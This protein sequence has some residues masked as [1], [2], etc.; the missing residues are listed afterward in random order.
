MS[1]DLHCLL[2]KLVV[3]LQ[4]TNGFSTLAIVLWLLSSLHMN[5]A[6]WILLSSPKLLHLLELV[7][8]LNTNQHSICLFK[9][10]QSILWTWKDCLESLADQP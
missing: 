5:S 7:V 2:S 6:L 3:D 1:A 4:Q 10:S 9:F 8:T